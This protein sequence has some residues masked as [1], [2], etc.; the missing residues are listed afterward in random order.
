MLESELESKVVKLCKLYN[1]VTYK[2]SSPSNRGVP[3][4][5][6]ISNGS[7]LFLELKQ[8]GKKPTPLQ[9]H[10]IERLRSAGCKADW[11]DTYDRASDI[12][13]RHVVL[14]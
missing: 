3:D 4:R 13:L 14:S 12:I 9:I 11:A 10:E 6:I 2:F 5:V 1:L 8:R 7:V